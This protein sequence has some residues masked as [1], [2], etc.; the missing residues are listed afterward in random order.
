MKNENLKLRKI[1]KNK[2]Q[3]EYK[4]KNDKRWMK[5]LKMKITD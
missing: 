2:T 4:N 3:N 5:L 1:L